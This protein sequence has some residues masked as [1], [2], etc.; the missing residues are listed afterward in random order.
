MAPVVG[1]E[2][3]DRSREYDWRPK[4]A[5]RAFLKE[6][7]FP[8]QGYEDVGAFAQYRRL[9]AR[10]VALRA[11]HVLLCHYERAESFCV[12]VTLRLLGRR[13]Y[14]MFDSKFDDKPRSAWRELFKKLF[15][16][17][18]C[19]ALVSSSRSRAYL[20]FLGYSDHWIAEGY[21]TVSIARV[22]ALAG[23]EPA[24][25]GV[26]FASRHFTVVARFVPKKNLGLAIKA[27]ALYRAKSSSNRRD[28]VICGSGPL[29]A[30]LEAKARGI[31][32]IRFMGFLQEDGIAQ[33]LANSLALILPSVEEQWGLVVNEALAMGAPVL[34]ADNVGARDLLVRTAVDG[35]VFEPDN[36]EGLARLM[37]RLA[38]DEG[39]WRRLAAGALAAAPAGDVARFVEGVSVLTGIHAVPMAR[40]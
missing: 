5:E 4:G 14:T 11:R 7:L 34:A 23:A 13:V 18:Y 1:I 19:G 29:G 12:A 38:T 32:G 31:D 26:P 37:W 24:P 30:E 3:A 36:A 17:P 8:G 20:K 21:D 40:K 35:Y 15:L 28:L 6:T 25:G 27:Y 10:C 2:I 9:V 39:E 16:L 22:R 33:T